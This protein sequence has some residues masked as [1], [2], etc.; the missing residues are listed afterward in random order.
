MGHGAWAGCLR[1]HYC[2]A[3]RGSVVCGRGQRAN[4]RMQAQRI[5]GVV[6]IPELH[7]PRES[8]PLP[9]AWTNCALASRRGGGTYTHA[10]ERT[11]ERISSCA[12]PC[13]RVLV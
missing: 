13:D 2:Q 3:P 12:C 10:S 1:G 4:G 11:N 9:R 8:P 5:N 6:P 7:G